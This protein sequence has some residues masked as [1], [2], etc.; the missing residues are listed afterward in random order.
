MPSMQP[1][2]VDR[3]DQ[4]RYERLTGEVEADVVV[5]GAGIVGA[6]AALL[7]RQQGLRV[8]LIEA[9]R[10]ASQVTGGSSAK[11]TSQHSLIYGELAR[12]FDE[13]LARRYGAANEWA[14]GEIER[15]VHTLE[16]EC[17]FE[18]RSAYTYA[19]TPEREDDLREEARIAAEV[20]LPAQFTSDVPLPFSTVGAVRF[21]GQAQFDAFAYAA[22]LVA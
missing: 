16:I 8:V 21:D 11:V 12:I 22:G 14:I 9:L 5:I 7:L 6:T 19:I 10:V 20:G 15:M 18:R 1:L 4:Q 13:Q 3:T 2:W 17:A